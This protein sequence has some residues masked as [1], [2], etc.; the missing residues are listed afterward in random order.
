MDGSRGAKAAAGRKEQSLREIVKPGFLFQSL[1]FKKDCLVSA[2]ETGLHVC[3]RVKRDMKTTGSNFV[4]R[5]RFTCQR[6]Q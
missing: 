6:F 1:E 4:G 3:T 5:M 2:G